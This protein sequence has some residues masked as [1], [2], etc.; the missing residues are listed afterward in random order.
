[1]RYGL[2]GVD[3]QAEGEGKIGVDVEVADGLR[4]VVDLEGEVVLGEGLDE[5]AFFVADDDG[6]VDEA[7]VDGEGGGGWA[8][9]GLLGFCG[10]GCR[11]GFVGRLEFAGQGATRPEGAGVRRAEWAAGRWGWSGGRVGSD[12]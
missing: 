12:S 6:E 7:G 2:A 8:S 5:G 4:V 9:G 3:E 10:W 1:M 11:T